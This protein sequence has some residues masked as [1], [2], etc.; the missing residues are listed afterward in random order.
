MV[1]LLPPKAKA[2]S[3]NTI[4][5]SM[6]SDLLFMDSSGA[7]L[8]ARGNNPAEYGKLQLNLAAPACR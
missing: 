5:K 4:R 3:I 2:I 8:D 7:S 1:W 6:T